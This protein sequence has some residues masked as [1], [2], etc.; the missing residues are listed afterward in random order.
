MKVAPKSLNHEA[1]V[2]LDPPLA[3]NNLSMSARRG[4]S[5]KFLFAVDTWTQVISDAWTSIRICRD[6][7]R[8]GPAWSSPTVAVTAGGDGHRRTPAW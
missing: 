4:M 6:E 2:G 8:R 5:A 7:A 3:S 1:A